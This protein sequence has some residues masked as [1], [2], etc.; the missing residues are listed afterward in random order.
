MRSP[1]ENEMAHVH[2]MMGST[3]FHHDP[4]LVGSTLFHHDPELVGST[5]F[6]PDPE[7]LFSLPLLPL[8]PLIETS[9]SMDAADNERVL[10]AARHGRRVSFAPDQ[11]LERVRFIPAVDR[12]PAEEHEPCQGRVTA[13]TRGS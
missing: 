5:L 7:L 3:M 6:H 12:R 11:L 1:F 4:E 9:P 10:R 13:V 8:L 2:A